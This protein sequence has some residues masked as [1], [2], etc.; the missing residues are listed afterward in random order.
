MTTIINDLEILR[1]YRK[2]HRTYV[3][4]K[5]VCG[6]IG[7]AVKKHIVSGHTKSCGCRRAKVYQP[8]SNPLLPVTSPE[9]KLYNQYVRDANKRGID[10]KI[11]KSVFIA[12]TKLNC[13]Y[14]GD[15][16]KNTIEYKNQSIAWNGLDRIDSNGIYEVSNVRTCCT[17]CNRAKH[18]LSEKDFMELVKRIYVNNFGPTQNWVNSVESNQVANT[19]PSLEIKESRKV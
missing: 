10:F 11:K 1:E 15:A 18:Y 7:N 3:E 16:P 9:N 2:N 6:K 14:C 17:N 5:C 8:K 4:F 12:L 13:Y 19:E